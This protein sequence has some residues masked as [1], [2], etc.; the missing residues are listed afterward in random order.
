MAK[1]I[2]VDKLIE[3]RVSN[4]P[5]VIAANVEPAAD[6]EPV[7]RCK[8]CEFYTNNSNDKNLRKGYCNRIPQYCFDKRKP[9][10]FCSLGARMDG[11]K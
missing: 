9:D 3:G 2:D 10:D 4:D 1:Y 5:V 7:V 11:E 8:D 6:V